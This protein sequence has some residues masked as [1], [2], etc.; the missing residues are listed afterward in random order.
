M[1]NSKQ[2]A[3]D[4]GLSW[5]VV[6]NEMQRVKKFLSK[7]A[8]ALAPCYADTGPID[9]APNIIS[10]AIKDSNPR[11]FRT[12][13]RSL[14][15]V[16][17]DALFKYAVEHIPHTLYIR[18]L[19]KKNKVQAY[20]KV[21]KAD[22]LH[23]YK[24][25]AFKHLGICSF[26]LLKSQNLTR[27]DI[28][29]PNGK[30]PSTVLNGK[31]PS[32]VLNVNPDGTIGDADI[33]RSGGLTTTTPSTTTPSTTTPSNPRKKIPNQNRNPFLPTP[34]LLEVILKVRFTK[35]SWREL[36]NPIYM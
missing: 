12:L 11:M 36:Q 22:T 9:R 3:L 8:N 30:P 2:Y 23:N 20:E 10:Y 29:Y 13:F 18:A 26:I 15:T 19:P 21:Y 28:E 24:H 6:N 27:D 33:E 1:N 5:A 7:G 34:W 35:K 14:E 4:H 31:P 25:L 17:C 16:D 32:T